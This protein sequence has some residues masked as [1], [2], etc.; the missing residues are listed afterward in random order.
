VGHHLALISVQSDVASRAIG[1][2]PAAGREA[3]GHV[4]AASRKALDELRDTV[5]L[6]RRPG[7]PVTPTAIPA[8]GLDALD[9]L[10][11]SLRRTGL[12]VDCLV[13][14]AGV[15]LAPAADRTA[16]RVVQEALTNV[17]KHS[18][19]RQARVTLAYDRRE[20]RIT[21]DDIGPGMSRATG[22]GGRPAG[23]MGGRQPPPA[24]EGLDAGV[25]ADRHGI[26]GMRERFLA[27]GGH[28]TAGPRP[29]GAFQVTAMLPHQPRDIAAEPAQAVP[30][31][32]PEATA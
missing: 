12:A 22:G 2:D 20:L 13:K 11:G 26:V 16:Y 30:G 18:T 25:L 7:D 17:Y 19:S 31:L 5:S 6:L 9:D 15:T 29:G 1:S 28:C 21:V 23:A 4:K 8:P 27:I 3:L 24:A 10:L 32:L 14:G